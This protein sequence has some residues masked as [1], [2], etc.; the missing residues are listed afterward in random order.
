MGTTL[1]RPTGCDRV[2]RLLASEPVDMQAA[3]GRPAL[4]GAAVSA[5]K[6]CRLAD[7][8]S[9]GREVALA[10]VAGDGAAASS[11]ACEPVRQAAAG[12][13]Y[14]AEYRS[15][16]GAGGAR[17]ARHRTHTETEQARKTESGQP[18]KLNLS[19][20]RLRGAQPFICTWPAAADRPIHAADPAGPGRRSDHWVWVA[21]AAQ[22][23]R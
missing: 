18:T 13:T 11:A 8:L 19:R 22:A 2:L 1:I 10:V 15:T 3:E 21:D 14:V 9:G 4:R 6:G 5:D 23:H 16:R 7:D 20:A 12:D 17:R